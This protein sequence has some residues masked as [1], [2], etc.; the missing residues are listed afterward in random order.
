MAGTG[1]GN[2]KAR[3]ELGARLRKI[4]VRMGRSSESVGRA[5]GISQSTLT[6]TE[7][8]DRTCTE[9][10]FYALVDFFGLVGGEREALELLAMSVWNADPPWWS[11]FGDVISA[12]YATVLEYED[13]ATLRQD[14][15]LAVMPPLLQTEAYARE[16][17]AVGFNDLNPDQV[18][19]LVEVRT[20]RQRRVYEDPCLA[21][22]AVITQAV[23]EF[24]VGGS[25]E[26]DA[27]LRHLLE[28]TAL[29]HVEVRVI[30]FAAGAGGTQSNPFQIL[31][32]GEG[33]P[34]V[35]FG[36]GVGGST[37]MDDPCDV[38]RITRLFKNLA[39]HALSPE[40]SR[41]LIATIR[42]N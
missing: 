17:T 37:F 31:S 23:L 13:W 41:E 32:Y 29:P 30:P 18:D 34:S 36:Q 35:A 22:E 4:R 1:P 3:R 11:R 10:E 19:D 21:I 15:Q 25:A 27:Q 2:L 33:E 38:R 14:Y 39:R 24:Q 12:N 9:R 6:R 42:K 7:T 20:C 26:H 16:V 40:D 8:G 5:I 28:M